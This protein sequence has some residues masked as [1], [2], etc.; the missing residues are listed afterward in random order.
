VAAT[1][2]RLPV[3]YKFLREP[4]SASDGMAER[5]KWNEDRGILLPIAFIPEIKPSCEVDL[6]ALGVGIYWGLP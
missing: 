5:R 1:A 6:P 3:L 2:S 4:P